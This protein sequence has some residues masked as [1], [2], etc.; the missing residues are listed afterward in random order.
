MWSSIP[1]LGQRSV[2]EWRPDVSSESSQLRVLSDRH[3]V[4]RAR[5][6]GAVIPQAF[7]EP[8]LGDFARQP[9]RLL[10]VSGGLPAGAL[11]H[12]GRGRH[13]PP[14][15]IEL[16]SRWLAR[17]A[18]GTRPFLPAVPWSAVVAVVVDCEDSADLIQSDIFAD[19]VPL[20]VPIRVDPVAFGDV[21]GCFALDDGEILLEEQDAFDRALAGAIMAQ[22]ECERAVLPPLIG[23]DHVAAWAVESIERRQELLGLP[24]LDIA[25]RFVTEVLRR[26]L[27]QPA[28]CSTTDLA[29]LCRAVGG[30]K[31][32]TGTPIEA[33]LAAM[34]GAIASEELAVADLR[35]SDGRSILLRALM[36][37][38]LRDSR[39]RIL[40]ARSDSLAAGN[41]VVSAAL[42]FH[43]LMVGLGGVSGEVKEGSLWLDRCWE[44]WIDALAA[45]RTGCR[46]EPE[47]E[48]GASADLDLNLMPAADDD[49]VG[50]E[51]SAGS[52]STTAVGFDRDAF[53][54]ALS[55]CGLQPLAEDQPLLGTDVVALGSGI[56]AYLAVS[57]ESLEICVVGPPAIKS[58]SAIGWASL[59]DSRSP[60]YSR[61]ALLGLLEAAAS[62]KATPCIEG[63]RL[64][65]RV[66]V[67]RSS[68]CLSEAVAGAASLMQ[69]MGW[70]VTR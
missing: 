54:S 32:A 14:V 65:F 50:G 36:L 48:A 70:S 38:I 28:P 55:A 22:G 17:A 67:E 49:G 13:N 27:K 25:S 66:R 64:G 15:L 1:A 30:E 40:G 29:A 52:S 57:R 18:I 2:D 39:E 34:E 60:L 24:R 51:G 21:N 23:P 53:M 62:G 46:L 4:V 47:V 8:A 31:W 33:W 6:R 45:S 16:D 9:G 5:S 37:A 61:R 26:L 11:E 19:C 7:V 10:V 35:M 3:G 68:T 69:T 41:A 63:A 59:A 43:G 12:V 20:R 56:S 44:C 42:L 58:G